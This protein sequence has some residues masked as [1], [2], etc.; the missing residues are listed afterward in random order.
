MEGPVGRAKKNAVIHLFTPSLP[1]MTP[2]DTTGQLS[3]ILMLK[4][5][6][7]QWLQYE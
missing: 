4:C 3:L 7:I 2:Q 1:E 5:I 6:D